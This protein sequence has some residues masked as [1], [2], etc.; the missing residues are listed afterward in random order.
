MDDSDRLDDNEPA[1]QPK[2][3]R[4]M[5][6]IARDESERIKKL[7]DEWVKFESP[8]ALRRRRLLQAQ[9]FGEAIWTRGVHVPEKWHET[10]EVVA[11][12]HEESDGE[13]SKNPDGGEEKKAEPKNLTWLVRKEQLEA[14]GWH[15]EGGWVYPPPKD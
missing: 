5:S 2:D 14:D 4:K 3:T 12:Q 13:E 1:S 8:E 11:A 10:V 6:Q 7:A 9:L 15:F